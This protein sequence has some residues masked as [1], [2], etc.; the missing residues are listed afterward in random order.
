GYLPTG[1]K[2]LYDAALAMLL[3]RRDRERGM[4]SVD[5]VELGEEAQL[6]LLQR[7]AYALGLSGRAEV[8]LETAEASVDRCLPSVARPGGLEG[9]RRRG[10]ARCSCAAAGSAGPPRASW[11]SC[12]APSRTTWAPGTRWRRATW[13]SSPATRTT[14]SGKT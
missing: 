3:T 12:T 14:P 7:L 5:E 8:D 11:T 10:C 9:A 2:E 1:R 4:G 6:E 13:T